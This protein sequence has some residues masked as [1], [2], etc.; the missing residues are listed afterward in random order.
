MPITTTGLWGQITDFDNLY[1]AY[2]EARRGKRDRS[3]VLRFSANVEENLVNLQNHLLWKS[4]APGKPR[5]FV[6]KEPKLRLIQA[7]PFEDRVI[8]HA[9]VRVV[10][11]IFERKFIS[12]SYACRVGMGTQAA[13]ARAQRFIRV[14]KRNHGPEV[15][16]LKADISKFFASI[17]HSVLLGEISRTISDRD[18]LWLWQQIICGYGNETGV[19]LPVGALT[20]QLGANILLNRLDHVA[21]DDLGIKHYVRYMDDFIAVLPN[22]ASAASTLGDLAS[23]VEGLS[24]ELNP[25]TA[26][27]PW[28]RGLDFCG[29]R[30]WPTHILPRK[31]NIKR[32]RASF[33]TLS[34][35]YRAGLV[36]QKHV[37]QRVCSFLAY[38]KHCDARRTVIGVLGDLRLVRGSAASERL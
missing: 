6:V 33:R 34:L 12:D 32:A 17:R 29:Y 22:K 20:S 37:R 36:D 14:A 4:W 2:L 19:G 8:H 35:R 13:V 23:V 9:L 18:V 38:A 31:R 26:I 16:V 10:N 27:H 28:Q 7:P 25:K 11:P 3:S 24:L 21:K 5:E 30:I 1:Q 15:Y